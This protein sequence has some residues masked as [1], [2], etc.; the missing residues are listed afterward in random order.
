MD[1]NE[2][3]YLIKTGIKQHLKFW[4]FMLAL[5]VAC[6]C[7]AGTVMYIPSFVNGIMGVDQ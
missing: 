3:T 5:F 2:F 6:A 4:A 7:L 1:D